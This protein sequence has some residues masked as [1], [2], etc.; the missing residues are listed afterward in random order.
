MDDASISWSSRRRVAG[1]AAVV[2]VLVAALLL[3]GCLVEASGP[4]PSSSSRL[5][6]DS[7]GPGVADSGELLR[8]E[9]AAFLLGSVLDDLTGSNIP[10]PNVRVGDRAI[11]VRR[12]GTFVFEVGTLETVVRVAADG[13]APAE[14]LA[15]AGQ[16]VIRLQRARGVSVRLVEAGTGAPVRDFAVSMLTLPSDAMGTAPRGRRVPL[17]H[18]SK[19]HEAG[20]AWFRDADPGRYVVWCQPTTNAFVAPTPSIFAW[21]QG[22]GQYV[23][24]AA[25]AQTLDV[26]IVAA[27]G[28]SEPGPLEVLAVRDPRGVTADD[29]CR[30][31]EVVT[32]VVYAYD[33]PFARGA[34][35]VSRARTG[36]GGRSALTVPRGEVVTV[37]VADGSMSLRAVQ[38]RAT[39]DRER[40]LVITL[41]PGVAVAGRIVPGEFVR[42]VHPECQ[43]FL[44]AA[45]LEQPG[46]MPRPR[47]VATRRDADNE[48]WAANIERDGAFVFPCLP[49][50]DWQLYLSYYL[51]E[52]HGSY[53]LRTAEVGNHAWWNGGRKEVVID[54]SGLTPRHFDLVCRF[55]GEPIATRVVE[56]LAPQSM[57]KVATGRLNADG[58]A[59]LRVEA[60][61]FVLQCRPAARAPDRHAVVVLGRDDRG[62]FAVEFGTGP[63]EVTLTAAADG[64]SVAGRRVRLRAP[65]YQW[66]SPE[67]TTDARGVVVIS[68]VACHAG[69]VVLDV[70]VA[71]A[72]S[73]YEI[74]EDRMAAQVSPRTLTVRLSR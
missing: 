39:P 4:Q 64:Q 73:S 70:N 29:G 34:V 72:W 22:H 43:E 26:R 16:V 10:E 24:E 63:V 49:L 5:A 28:V 65:E 7:F 54:A 21:P 13:Y 59:A 27:D 37:V 17:V 69:A 44:S 62:L 42:A 18:E 41:P 19:V 6:D 36:P 23:V 67:Q 12:D 53:Q 71:G 14:V 32:G 55:G 52:G 57:R 58:T 25:V 45:G 9:R 1:I 61:R 11:E 31:L 38:H 35:V 15:V 20:W 74:E 47:V 50:G 8:H 56:A 30:E 2:A 68:D 66:V 60:G 48:Q 51:V 33:Y 3:R 46:D 40:E